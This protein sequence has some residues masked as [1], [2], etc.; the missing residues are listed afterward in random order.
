MILVFL[1]Q[2]LHCVVYTSKCNDCI[3]PTESPLDYVGLSVVMS[4]DECD[5]RRC[6]NLR[7]IDDLID[8]QE[9]ILS[10]HLGRTT[11]LDPRITLEPATG[12]VVIAADDGLLIYYDSYR[13]AIL[14]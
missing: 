10:F 13:N 14:M 8:E 6:T 11:G 2:Q 1:F 9:E 12:S 5:Y 4:F 3:Y 7:I